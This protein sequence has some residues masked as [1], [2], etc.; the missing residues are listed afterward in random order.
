MSRKLDRRAKRSGSYVRLYE[1]VLGSPAYRDLT[2][3]ARSLLLEFLRIFRPARNGALSISI[4]NCARLIR[5]NKDTAGR[6]FRELAEHGFIVMT[7][8]EWWQERKA[9]EWRLT[10]EESGGQE[11][12]DDWKRWS[13]GS[14]LGSAK[15]TRSQNRGQACPDSGY[16]L[17]EKKGQDLIS[18]EF[19]RI[20]TS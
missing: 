4:V 14:P 3:A 12:T 10:F 5:V 17:V 7:Q 6:A 9:R 13:P 16:R 15:K 19:K 1:E 11:P 18:E 2:P 8:G 20:A